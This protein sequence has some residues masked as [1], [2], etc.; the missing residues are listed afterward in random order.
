MDG[1]R[2]RVISRDPGS[3]RYPKVRARPGLRCAISKPLPFRV[4]RSGACGRSLIDEGAAD[5]P[6][7]RCAG[8]CGGRPTTDGGG[9]GF[10]IELPPPPPISFA[11]L[12]ACPVSTS[13]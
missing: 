10:S 5:G 12:F 3:L 9:R 13:G 7:R 8:V 2:C 11:L 4:S 1:K 6:V